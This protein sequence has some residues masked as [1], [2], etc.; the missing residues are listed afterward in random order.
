M[1]CTPV[2]VLAITGDVTVNSLKSA[3]ASSTAIETGSGTSAPSTSEIL[4]DGAEVPDPVSI[5]VLE[6]S[7]DFKEFTVTS[8]V[9]ASTQ[10]GVHLIRTHQ[11][12]TIEPIDP[13]VPIAT[14]HDLTKY[15]SGKIEFHL[16]DATGAHKWESIE[17][18]IQETLRRHALGQLEASD[19]VF[20]NDFPTFDLIDAAT[21]T[22]VVNDNGRA[23]SY[24]CLLYTS[25]SPRDATLSRMPSSA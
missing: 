8:P 10:T 12:A 19:T 7:A 23:L 20:D 3:E 6:A 15:T 18:D 9:I 4:V 2:W 24:I 11:P 21:G 5:A 22:F 14:G 16:Q 25:P 1:R 13:V 17:V